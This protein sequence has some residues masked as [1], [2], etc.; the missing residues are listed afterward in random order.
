M[1]YAVA[2]YLS[3]I[4]IGAPTSVERITLWPLLPKSKLKSQHEP[5]ARPLHRPL[6]AALERGDDQPS[7]PASRSASI[8]ARV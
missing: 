2:T 1:T 3:E 4:E 6:A 7:A 8:S 5:A